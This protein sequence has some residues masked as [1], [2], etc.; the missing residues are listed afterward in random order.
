MIQIWKDT[1]YTELDTGLTSMTY[2]ITDGVNNVF[3]GRAARKP[4][5]LSIKINIS[6]IVSDYLSNELISFNDGI[7]TSSGALKT[8]YLYNSDNVLLEQ[9]Q[10]LYDWSYEDI[11]YTA[12]TTTSHPING[13]YTQGQKVITS[14]V[15]SAYTNTIS[16]AGASEYCGEYALIYLNSYGGWDSLLIE[17]KSEK[18][19]RYTSYTTERFYNNT[20]REFGKN[21]YVNEIAGEWELH[22]GWLNDTQAANLV[23]NLLSSNKVYLQDITK[24]TIIPVVITNS[25]GVYKK[26]RNEKEFI[27]YQIEIE[28]SQNKERK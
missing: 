15:G 24:H 22:T 27:S 4:D 18:T 19:D 6:R 11:P 20:T 14:S 28:E 5:E 17:G 25:E 8:F 26:F 12:A 3:Y 21:R 13:H 9:Y 1:I 10:M 23:K 16:T 7:Y 2:Y